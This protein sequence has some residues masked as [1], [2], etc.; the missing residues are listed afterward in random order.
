MFEK[1][2][3]ATARKEL[4]DGAEAMPRAEVFKMVRLI[5]FRVFTLI[6]IFHLSS[7]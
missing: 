1:M 5:V 2:R 7:Q 4:R 3:G 6:I